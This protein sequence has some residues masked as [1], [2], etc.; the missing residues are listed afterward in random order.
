MAR[1]RVEAPN[2]DRGEEIS[3]ARKFRVVY[4][5]SR[6]GK[7]HNINDIVEFELTEE[8]EMKLIGQSL[9]EIKEL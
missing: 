2:E 6:N 7:L 8:E 9:E 5:L 3:T 1:K 4:P